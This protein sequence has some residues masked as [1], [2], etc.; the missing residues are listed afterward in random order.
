[1]ADGGRDTRVVGCDH[2]SALDDVLVVTVRKSFW[3]SLEAA[4]WPR[5][6]YARVFYGH[7]TNLFNSLLVFARAVM[8]ISLHP[9]KVVFLGSVERTVPWF[10]L[11]RAAGLLRGAKLVVTNQLALDESQ[12]D[13][14]ARVVVYASLQAEALGSKGVFVPLPADGDLAAALAASRP[15]GYVFS[16]GGAGRDYA[17]L[18]DAARSSSFEV[19]IVTFE[20]RAV[21]APANVR[22]LGPMPV[23]SFLERMAGAA[24]VV[25]PL[26]TASSPHGQ[27]TVVQALALGKP[28]VA[29]RS[30]SVADYIRDGE[31]GLLVDAGDVEGLRCALVRL[32]AD[33][34]MRDRLSA[35]ARAEAAALSYANHAERLESVCRSLL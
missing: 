6:L 25:V 35:G 3:A 22:V 28:V 16:G 8:A 21:V 26:D 19:E 27:T 17:C 30:I 24:V 34:A 11:A 5:R 31:N 14:V 4:R 23:Q 32:L 29:T 7:S 33:E 15:G 13:Q 10:I 12:L 9:P 20:P 1:V 2:L 18:I